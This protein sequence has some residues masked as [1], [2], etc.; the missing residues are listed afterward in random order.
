MDAILQAFGD[1][2]ASVEEVD[3]DIIDMTNETN[4]VVDEPNTKDFLVILYS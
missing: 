1:K 2:R 3:V 4:F